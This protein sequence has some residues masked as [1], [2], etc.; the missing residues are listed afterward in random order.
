M[1]D[2]FDLHI[3]NRQTRKDPL[4]PLS[5][6]VLPFFSLSLS[7]VFHKA[8][9]LAALILLLPPISAPGLSVN[10]LTVRKTR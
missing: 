10:L 7:R 3:E 9:A 1:L 5:P 8:R 4:H 2:L 6:D